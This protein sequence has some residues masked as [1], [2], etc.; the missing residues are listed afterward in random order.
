VDGEVATRD[1]DFDGAGGGIDEAEI[2]G[3]SGAGEEE[4]GLW[5]GDSQ[6]SFVR[7]KTGTLTKG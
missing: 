7:M 6:L 4:E 5:D 1:G 2:V 3:G